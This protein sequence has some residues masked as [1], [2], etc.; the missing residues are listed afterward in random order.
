MCMQITL[1]KTPSKIVLLTTSLLL[2]VIPF[3]KAKNS[4][5][6]GAK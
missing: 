2:L 1:D 3:R 6:P 4:A 5:G